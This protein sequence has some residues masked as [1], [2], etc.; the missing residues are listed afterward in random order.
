M[1][2]LW[3]YYSGRPPDVNVFREGTVARTQTP[4]TRSG[5]GVRRAMNRNSVTAVVVVGIVAIVAIVLVADRGEEVKTSGGAAAALAG[6]TLDGTAF[7]LAAYR[8]KPVVVNFFASWCGPC[9]DEAPDLADFAGSHPEVTF[10][11]VDTFNDP[12]ADANAFLAKYGLTYPVVV[13]S[14]GEIAGAWGVDGIPTTVFLDSSGIERD[15]IVGGADRAAFE[16]SLR[17]VQ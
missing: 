5:R 16:A 2:Y 13:D 10:V 9:N 4:G 15:R 7:D 6:K 12:T 8:G 14:G 17:N 11:G 3:G 1:I